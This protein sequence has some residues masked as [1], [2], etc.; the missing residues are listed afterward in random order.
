MHSV[1]SLH[2][3]LTSSP[4]NLEIFTSLV[5][6]LH[7]FA[8]E[9]QLTHAE[10]D[11][12]IK[13]LTRTGKESTEFKNEFVLL[14]DCLG[15]SVLV[16]ELEHPR[17]EGCTL[18]CEPGPFWTTDAPL[19]PSG[20]LLAKPS[21]EGEPL[22]FS[23]TV[24]NTK[25][26]PIEGVIAEVWQADGEGAYDVQD[27][28]RDGADDRGRIIAQKDGYFC[29][30][31]VLPTA[32]PIPGDGPTGDLLRALGRHPHRASHLHFTITA[33]G[34]DSL[35]TA[36]YP[37]HSPF[38]GTDPVFATKKSLICD[39]SEERDAKKWAE[40][41]WEAGEEKVQERVWK[42]NYGFVLASEEEVKELKAK[43]AKAKN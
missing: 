4:R 34:Y 24:K 36:L 30:K 5:N 20:S 18:S 12:A 13:F 11:K 10:W 1:N 25:G 3:T 15:F 23:A 28:N 17:P 26:E 37:S 6:H 33:P 35:T 21:T 27:P 2:Q 19:V 7:A 31:A 14:S 22:F 39:L 41:G 9:T 40:L 43:Q 38:L 16:D 42:W 29:Y 8:R 32:Y